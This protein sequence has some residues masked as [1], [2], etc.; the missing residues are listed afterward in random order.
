VKRTAS[1]RTRKT[2]ATRTASGAG[3]HNQLVRACLIALGTAVVYANSLS[4]PFIFDDQL[5]IVENP[6]IRTI[7]RA[8]TQP[9][10]TPL[11]G[12]PIAGLS[13]AL[14][15]AATELDPAAYRATNIVVHIACA[16]L[17]FGIVR[18]MLS[19]PRFGPVFTR[20]APDL[21]LA[22]ALLWAVHPLATDAVTYVTQRTES[23]IA[24]F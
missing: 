14:N 7:A 6:A 11:A 15:Y 21:A 3:A 19:L 23:L 13:F 12:R 16:L 20:R 1:P 24:M 22:V 10:N 18:R 9:A 5:A 17:L 8:A 2:G 4:A